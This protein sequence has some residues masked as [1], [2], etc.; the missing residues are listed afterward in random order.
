MK[1]VK[2]N[3]GRK[4]GWLKGKPHYDENG[5]P[6]GGIKAIVTDQEGRPVELEGG[7]VIINKEASAKHWKE[8]SRINQSAGNGVAIGPPS[9]NFDEDPEEYKEGGRVIEFNA[10]HTPN[11]W[12][13]EYAKKIKKDHPEIWKLGGNIFGNQAF[14]NLKRVS[15]RGYWLDSEKWMYIKWRSYVARHKGDFR[16]E[17][18]VAM[19]KWV[20]KVDKGWAYMKKLIQERIDKIEEKQKK[21]SGWSHKM[22]EGGR[23]IAQTPAPKKERIFGSKV[24]KSGSAASKSSAKSIKLDDSVIESIKNKIKGTG[25][26]LATAKAVVRRGMGAYSSS[27]RPTIS[28]GKPN[29]R[30]AW[31]LARLN[32]F[33]YKKDHGVSK[34]GKYNQD[35]DLMERGGLIAPNGKPSNLT[36]EQYKLVRTPAFKEWFGDWE[37]SPETSSKVIDENGE[38]LVCYH[39]TTKDFNEFNY[40]ENAINDFGIEGRGFYFSNKE[41]IAKQ[42]AKRFIKELGD[43]DTTGG[44]VIEVFLKIV[45]PASRK[46]TSVLM[47]K[48]KDFETN[49]RETQIELIKQGFNGVIKKYPSGDNAYEFVVFNSTQIKLADGTNT[50]FDGSNPD[51]RFADG[52]ELSKGIKTEQEHRKTLEK[53]AS[54]ELT[55]DQAI[56]RT[57]KDHLKE[58]PKYYTKLLK[59]ESKMATGGGVSEPSFKLN[60]PTGE[61]SKLTYTQQ[62]LVRTQTFKKWFG[63]WESAAKMF[64]AD[65]KENFKKHYEGVSKVL[66]MTTLEPRLVYH[67]TRSSDEFFMFDVSREKGVGRPYAYFAHE[68]E[69]SKNFTRFSQRGHSDSAGFLYKCFL[70]VRNPFMALGRDYEMKYK[71]SENWLPTIVGTMAWDKYETVAKNE[72]TENLERAVKQQIGDYL[73]RVAEINTVPFWNFMARDVNSDFKYFLVSYGYDGIFYTEELVSDFDPNNPA[74]YTKAVTVFSPNDIKLADGRNLDFNPME[75]DIRLEEGGEIEQSP[76]SSM[77]KKEELG[78]LLF[79]DKYAR[80]GNLTDLNNI[81]QQSPQKEVSKERMFVDDLIK[82]MKNGI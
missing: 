78:N 49:A 39:G 72:K 41:G 5:K 24:N 11:K 57:A 4:G 45:N 36:P 58:D 38:P 48:H 6:M 40:S 60:T 1:E 68:I 73:D 42:Y 65:N 46:E 13:L 28:G 47:S 37:N 32:A 56:E 16:I 59:M 67:G 71:N 2:T 64:L 52:G 7:E 33:I 51:I 62:V 55:V 31:G 23:T 20:D 35:D 26:S 19:L 53:I 61:P 15:E 63:D 18:V 77:N 69:Y 17:G 70:N 80:G 76:A 82:K 27:H 44:R 3:D 34:S 79:G 12:I 8:L 81:I 43:F 9:S 22:A 50:T 54:G 25:I 30:V 21:K 66:D 14:E 10:N 75:A 29:S 74:Q